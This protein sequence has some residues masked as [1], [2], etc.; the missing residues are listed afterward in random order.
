[1]KK[2]SLIALL[3]LLMTM[4]S[5]QGKTQ[6]VSTVIVSGYVIGSVYIETIKPDYTVEIK[7]YDRKEEKNLLV[8]IKK[9]LD[10]WINEGYVIDQ[11]TSNG[12]QGV[13]SYR[14]TYFLIKK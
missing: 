14:Y 4:V 12:S 11:T 10:F 5:F 8:E 7:E 13:L 6:E 2:V 9:E 1:M 3:T